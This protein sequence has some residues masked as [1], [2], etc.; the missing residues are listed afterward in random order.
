MTTHWHSCLF[1]QPHHII[2]SH[3]SPFHYTHHPTLVLCLVT[4]TLKPRPIVSPTINMQTLLFLQLTHNC[5]P[6]LSTHSASSFTHIVWLTVLFSI[7]TQTALRILC[8]LFLV[9]IDCCGHLSVNQMA[10]CQPH[11]LQ[12]EMWGLSRYGLKPGRVS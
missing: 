12:G 10:L 3:A 2:I 11:K 8:V 1:N 9:T 7:A 5:S 6:S 4:H